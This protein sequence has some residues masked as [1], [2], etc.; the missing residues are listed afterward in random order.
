[1]I[2]NLGVTHMAPILILL[3]NA[4]FGRAF[5]IYYSIGIYGVAVG[6]DNSYASALIILGI[7]IFGEFMEVI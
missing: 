5:M 3:L 2:L 1:M 7:W 4:F 6:V